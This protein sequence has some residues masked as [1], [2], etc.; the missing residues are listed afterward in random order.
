M[1][2]HFFLTFNFVLGYSHLTN[3]AM[4][5]SDEQQRG[6]AIHIHVSILP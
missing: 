2:K 4:I 3:N 1:G 6:S 5:V